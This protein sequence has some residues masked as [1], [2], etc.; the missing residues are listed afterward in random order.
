MKIK[1]FFAPDIR[2]AIKLVR[3]ELGADAVILSNRRV[4]GGVEIVSAVDYDEALAKET[5]GHEF[6]PHSAGTA[7]RPAQAAG[8]EAALRSE[9]RARVVKPSIVP[10]PVPPPAASAS[11]SIR[12]ATERVTNASQRPGT[13]S[14]RPT[15]PS[16]RSGSSSERIPSVVWS[17]EP[18]LVE[19]R[20]EL[21]NLR[22]LLETQL[23]GLAWG[24]MQRRQPVKVELL[25]KL[26]KLGLS[27]PL[28]RDIAN[29]LRIR[30]DIGEMWRDALEHLESELITTDD[31]ILTHGGV[32]ALVGPTGVGKTTTIAK[33]AA[34][35]ALRHGARSV[36][37]V[38]T[39]SYRIGAY[40]QLRAYGRI[41]DVPVRLVSNDEELSRTL[42]DLSDRRLILIDTTGMSQRDLRLP[43]QLGLLR[44]GRDWL[45]TY[46]VLSTTARLSSLEEIVR[47]YQKSAL[48]GC[49]LT[50]VD[51]TTCLGSALSAVIAHRIPVAYVSDGQRVPEDLHTARTSTLVQRAVAI[52]QQHD[53][54]LEEE[55]FTN[56]LGRSTADAHA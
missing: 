46:L 11:S 31:D 51:E 3:D 23:A 6:K 8:L 34:R 20:E 19:M 25:Q 12:P 50:K 4:D 26:T 35:H 10:A 44:D 42:D 41:L 32:V 40:E 39:D 17:Q 29:S 1:R 2:Q 45:K 37:L 33:L 36:A 24:D 7:A 21:K 47:V 56:V 14:E 55:L 22:G 53:G 18:A 13:S 38:T 27:A 9:T 48:A 15:N 52:M 28:C 43:E 30:N 16:Q 49:V 54:L 5:S